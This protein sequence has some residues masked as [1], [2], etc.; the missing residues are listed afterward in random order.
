MLGSLRSLRA[1]DD[2]VAAIEY[3]VIAAL[4]GVGLIGSLVV[5]R[6]SLNCEYNTIA[7]IL[8]GGSASCAATGSTTVVDTGGT[9]NPGPTDPNGFTP[10]E[11]AAQTR[12]PAG[13]KVVHTAAPLPYVVTYEENYGGYGMGNGFYVAPASDPTNTYGIFQGD[14][15]S[16]GYY[17]SSQ[18]FAKDN[19]DPNIFPGSYVGQNSDGTATYMYVIQ[20][21]T[22]GNWNM[23]QVTG[24]DDGSENNT[25]YL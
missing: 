5:T 8:G 18:L 4:I 16:A 1:V 11:T 20:D 25:Y 7:S 10:L 3:A 9:T 21:P 15:A 17:G 6:T 24:P 22:S 14:A 12:L 2:G 23:F 19:V 13:Y